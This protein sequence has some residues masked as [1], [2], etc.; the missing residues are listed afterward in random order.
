MRR[1]MASLSTLLAA[2]TA[3]HG[4]GGEDLALF[5]R[6]HAAECARVR[7]CQSAVSG[8]GVDECATTWMRDAV[9]AGRAHVDPMAAAA[10]LSGLA[11]LG[12]CVTSGTTRT[13]AASPADLACRSYVVLDAVPCG[14]TTCD[15]RTEVCVPR[16]DCSFACVPLPAV[17]EPCAPL[18][19]AGAGC[20]S[21][22]CVPDARECRGRVSELAVAGLC[23]A[24]RGAP[25][26]AS[27]VCAPGSY[28]ARASA[29]CEDVPAPLD[30]GDVCDP[31]ADPPCALPLVCD[32]IARRCASA[33][34]IAGPC[35]SSLDCPAGAYCVDGTCSASSLGGDCEAI[36]LDFGLLDS[37][38]EGQLC[39]PDH[40]CRLEALAGDACD[41]SHVCA[42]GTACA[43]GRCAP[44]A[45]PGEACDASHPCAPHVACAGGTCRVDVPA[46]GSI[47]RPCLPDGT[48]SM[49]VCTTGTCAW[50]P[51]GAAC[52]RAADCPSCVAGTC[53]P[54]T[55]LARGERC[56][57][58]PGPSVCGEGLRCTHGWPLVNPSYCCP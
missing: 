42:P 18:C 58:G 40:R 51:D 35:S 41:D 21:G 12:D 11:A 6:V 13:L 47:G 4:A 39:G 30:V 25:C 15:P 33:S 10:C 24:A 56:T 34:P 55:V 50:L 57:L 1:V 37:C 46:D 48:C 29:T 28:C 53:Q 54:E 49:G 8:L 19:A 23:Y 26:S 16:S 43:G 22:A 17:G 27:G 9:A 36:P 44:I 2:C 20:V 3:A 31:S 5:D 38:P 7:A 52:A 32:P 45:M 14:D